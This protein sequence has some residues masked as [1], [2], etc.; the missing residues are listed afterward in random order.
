M[1]T[2]TRALAVIVLALIL[3][4]VLLT[5]ISCRRR[6]AQPSAPGQPANPPTVTRE[7][8]VVGP[9]VTYTASPT[10]APTMVPPLTVTMTPSVRAI[11]ES[12]PSPTPTATTTTLPNV[13]PRT[14]GSKN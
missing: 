1:T 11:R 12:P 13:L 4:D 2:R 10:R 8:I 6:D 7:L 9:I 14:G 3:I 5:V